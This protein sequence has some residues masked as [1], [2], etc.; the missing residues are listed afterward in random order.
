MGSEVHGTWCALVI[1]SANDGVGGTGGAY[2]ASLV[3]Y[4]I[5]Y[6]SADADAEFEAAFRAAQASD[7]DVINGSFFDATPF[8]VNYESAA[9]AGFADAQRDFAVE[10]RGGLGGI[11]V[12]AAG[13][14]D[15]AAGFGSAESYG[16]TQY[17][18]LSSHV[19][20]VIV[21]G[22]DHDGEHA[23]FA[24]GGE[25]LT[26]VAQAVNVVTS[27]HDGSQGQYLLHGTSFSTPQVA[28]AVAQM[29]E[30]N[31]ELGARDV[32]EILALSSRLGPYAEG[33]GVDDLPTWDFERNGADTWNGG[34]LKF[35]SEF[36]FGALDALAA[37]R[38]AE[39]WQT[40]HSW[41][42]VTTLA[43]AVSK[44]TLVDRGT[45]VGRTTVAQDL[46]VDAVELDLKF[47]HGS[48]RDLTITVVS[49]SG[50]ES[51]VLDGG[52]VDWSKWG[53]R[54]RSAGTLDW[55]FTS[56]RFWGED[57]RGTW[58]V[59]ITDRAADGRK[60]SQLTEFEL[61]LHGDA[62][63]G[64]QYVYTDDLSEVVDDGGGT[65]AL[66]W[67][68]GADTLNAAAVTSSS[69]L[70]LRQ[71]RACTIDGVQ[72]A[73]GAGC[74]VEDAVGGDGD[75]T[76]IGQELDNLLLGG[77]GDDTAYGND[78][79]DR[80]LGGVG[81]DRLWGSGGADEVAGEDGD[82]TVDGGGGNDGLSGGDGADRLYARDGDDE[83]TGGAGNDTLAGNAGNDGLDAGDGDDRVYGDE[84]D[85]EGAGGAGDDLV[86]G[87]IG[88][89]TLRGDA[90]LDIVYGRDGNDVAEGGAGN[91]T[92]AGQIGNDRLDGGE[93][94]DRVFGD[95]GNDE[96]AGGAGNDRLGGGAGEDTVRGGAGSD[97]LTG[98]DHDD[99]LAGGAGADILTGGLG[100]D[101]FVLTFDDLGS[102][103]QITDLAPAGEQIDLSGIWDGRGL[104]GNRDNWVRLADGP[105]G[106]CV[107]A[108]DADGAGSVRF[109]DLVRIDGLSR[110]Q[111]LDSLV[112]S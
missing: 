103:D 84:G 34:G 36:G 87:G 17:G 11:A 82:D 78:G 97:R 67:T 53:D 30:A 60:L 10:G 95:E 40:Q 101:L 65:L 29:L 89:D 57:A 85:D 106:G 107:L 99:I 31:P 28:S 64:R 12:L 86:D 2:D 8:A 46:D 77:R 74:A 43:K 56:N 5:N 105:D 66:G 88:N 9:W 79:D 20:N 26:V 58:E 93:G 14:A 70:D 21:G 69:V 96:V 39:T 55:S 100:A 81:D 75:D 47:T 48:W 71:G 59:R 50:T 61:R 22:F 72:V 73:V 76:L 90:G 18:A 7:V 109:A 54:D 52:V 37:T 1:G 49:P 62:P 80:I 45:M 32:R 38:L 13:N 15:Q 68:A 110:D 104:T 19:Y 6:A 27:R 91:D 44:P 42:N 108:V 102:V 111:V 16:E 83:V 51:V 33:T 3:A 23:W 4:R 98:D 94:D 41:A 25:S 24:R 35:S 92:V 63:A 112:L